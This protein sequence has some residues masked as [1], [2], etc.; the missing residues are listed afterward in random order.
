MAM[1]KIKNY[2]EKNKKLTDIK[3][4]ERLLQVEYNTANLEKLRAD[5]CSNEF[6]KFVDII[7]TDEEQGYIEN[8]SDIILGTTDTR[9]KDKEPHAVVEFDNS[10]FKCETVENNNYII[11][12]DIDKRRHDKKA[13]E[14]LIERLFYNNIS[15]N[16]V[17]VGFNGTHRA[18]NSDPLKYP[19]GNDVAKG[20]LQKIREQ[21]GEQVI[22][23][24][25]VGKE[26]KY[27]SLAK[28]FKKA[29]EKVHP[30]TAVN[31]ELIAFCGLDILEDE[32]VNSNDLERKGYILTSSVKSGL[33]RIIVPYLPPNSV[34]L[35]TAEN[36]TLM[37]CKNYT[38]F[39]IL[40]NVSRNKINSL[41]STAVSF[42]I[43]D[44]KKAVLIEKVNFIE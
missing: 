12:D 16:L 4:D 40:N 25:E 44:Y 24:A 21:A 9:L 3:E 31:G 27:K 26:Q 15:S 7:I 33:K 20:W 28:L 32:S 42:E 13:T 30:L 39:K 41:F 43:K 5:I 6:M 10:I 17:S 38:S 8:S 18:D 11:F 2:L 36:L 37:I 14:K 35:T 1:Q 29:K 23:S 19:L 22:N 34:L